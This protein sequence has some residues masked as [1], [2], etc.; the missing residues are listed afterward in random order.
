MWSYVFM[1]PTTQLDGLQVKRCFSQK[2][3]RNWKWEL[4]VDVYLLGCNTLWNRKQMPMFRR[5]ILP[6]QQALEAVYFSEKLVGLSTDE[7]TW[8]RT[9]KNMGSNWSSSSMKPMSQTFFPYKLHEIIFR[10]STAGN[11]Y[12]T[13]TNGTY[14]IKLYVCHVNWNLIRT[15]HCLN[16]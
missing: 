13:K 2:G 14:S 11:N 7:Y 12:Q 3:L 9:K 16:V 15:F 1:R 8:R 6:P 4:R 5:K 10:F